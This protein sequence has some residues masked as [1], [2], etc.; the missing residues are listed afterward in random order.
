METNV[1]F[2]SKLMFTN[3]KNVVCKYM[4]QSQFNSN[5][6]SSILMKERL[7]E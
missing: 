6:L 4:I 1:L 3:E 2:C 5:V 7:F